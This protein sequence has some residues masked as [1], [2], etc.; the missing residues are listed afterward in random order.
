[1]NSGPG[2]SRALIVTAIVA[3]ALNLRPAVNSVGAVLPEVRTALGL[4][5]T[6]GGALTSL[7]PLCFALLG[8]VAP[9]LAGRFRPQR[10]VVVSLAAMAVGQF[11]RVLGSSVVTLF[12]GSIVALAGLAICNVLLPSLIR[13]FFVDRIPLMTAVYTSSLAVGATS[14]SALSIPIERGLNADWRTGLGV[15]GVTA[16]IALV[17]WLMMLFERPNALSTAPHR[18]LPIR[19]LLRS[20]VAWTLSMFFGLQSAQA[21]IV[22]AWLSQIVVDAGADLKTGGYAVG[23]FAALG[24]VLSAA[25][26][27]LLVRQSRL[28]AVVVTLGAFYVA[29][30]AGLLADPAKG[31]LWAAVIGVGSGTFPLALTL[32]ALRART[33][34]G[35]AALSAFTQCGGY[36]LASLGP[37]AVGWLHD[38]SHGWAVPIITLMMSASVMTLLGLQVAKPRV[39]EDDLALR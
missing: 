18:T 15:W 11:I 38:L 14:S 4:S 34:E 13:R 39:I 22:T 9:G 33:S 30:Y 12:A 17:P 8:L 29:G 6:A 21:Y 1:M 36:L 37:L 32:I 10:V 24:I 3:L 28:P 31:L 19:A 2:R 23:L 16:A 5:A 7:P 26:P 27:A 25:V 35:V 20:R